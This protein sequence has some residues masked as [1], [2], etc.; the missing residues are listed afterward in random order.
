MDYFFL[1]DEELVT[2]FRFIGIDG[3]AV[4]DQQHAVFVFKDITEKAIDEPYCRVLLLTEE[5]ADWLGDYMTDWQLSGNYP[6]LVEIPG[7]SGRLPD[8]KTLVEAIREAIGI[9]V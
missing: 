5:T 2:A 8:R 7:I 6:L 1:G 9:R 4:R 3:I